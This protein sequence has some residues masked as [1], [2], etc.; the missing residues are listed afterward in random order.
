MEKI[1]SY[2]DQCWIE[3]HGRSNQEAVEM[4]RTPEQEEEKEKAFAK[5]KPDIDKTTLN[6]TLAEAKKFVDDYDKVLTFFTREFP[7]GVQNMTSKQFVD[8]QYLYDEGQ[9][10]KLE[11]ARKILNNH[12]EKVG[13]E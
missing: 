9:R 6:M 3:K 12:N 5:F 1:G 10:K 11:E 2:Q 7:N 8:T 4:M 13:A